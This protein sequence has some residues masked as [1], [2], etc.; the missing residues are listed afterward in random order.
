MNGT[1]GCVKCGGAIY[2]GEHG[3]ITCGYGRPVR[4]IKQK[5]GMSSGEIVQAYINA[6]KQ[7]V[8]T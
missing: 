2:K 7:K 6:K 3:C 8:I 5:K 1:R 4:K